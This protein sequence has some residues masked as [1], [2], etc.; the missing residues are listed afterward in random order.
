M[1]KKALAFALCVLLLTGCSGPAVE[2]DGTAM[3]SEE[4]KYVALTVLTKI[5]R[6]LCWMD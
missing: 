6:R 5:Q 2:T 4:V 1:K 3:L